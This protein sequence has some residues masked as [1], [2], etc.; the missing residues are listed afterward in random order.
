MAGGISFRTERCGVGRALLIATLCALLAACEPARS[1]DEHMAAADALVRAGRLDEALLELNRAVK[2]AP[3]AP[4]PRRVLAEVYVAAGRGDLAEVSLEQALRRGTAPAAVRVTKARALVAQRD[5]TRVLAEVD[6]EAGEPSQRSALLL[7][8]AEAQLGVGRG[9]NDATVARAFALVFAELGGEQAGNEDDARVAARLA[10]LADVPAIARARAHTECGRAART[11]IEWRPLDVRSDEVLHV[12][13]GSALA[14]PAAAAA[15]ARD[16]ARVEI[17][18]ATYRGGVAVWAQKRLHI[19][20]VGGRPVITANGRSV[21]K[22]D[23]WLFTGDDVAIE[24]VELSGARAVSEKHGAAI[25]H[26]GSGLTLRHVFLHDNENGLMTGNNRPDSEILIDHSEFAHNGD[27]EGY[28]HN[29][30]VGYAKALVFR[31]SYSHASKG[32]HLLKSRAAA[33][34]IEASRLSDEDGSGSYV[35]DTPNGGVVR[36]VGSLLERGAGAVN[37]TLLSYGSDGLRY[38][39]N[40]L[41]VVNDGVY[42]HD[43]RAI[44][45]HNHVAVGARVVNVVF[46]GAPIVQLSGEGSVTTTL[47]WPD[48]GLADPRAL[49]FSPN[50]DSD[51]VDAGT[52]TEAEAAVPLLEYVHPVAYRHRLRVAQID[53]GA[54]ERCGL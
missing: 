44:A 19:V 38:P 26:V 16:G 14:T 43:P 45:V 52:E 2:A 7:A 46:A 11:T 53:I 32:G 51:V 48:N 33:T 1:L 39:E 15:V 5:W 28:A 25:R 13:P 31:G 42:N 36:I 4:E 9:P 49:D 6:V 18:A 27:N 41:L 24:N 47:T 35:I 23:I 34:T 29:L 40:S 3:D 8:R 12:S 54:Y 17:E 37:H 30:Y 22:R 21:E 10:E 20:G 50:A